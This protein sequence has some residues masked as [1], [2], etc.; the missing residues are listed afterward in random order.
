[1]A[2]ANLTKNS[3]HDLILKFTHS[4][5]RVPYTYHH[6]LV[7]SRLSHLKEMSRAEVASFSKDID[8]VTLFASALCYLLEQT[9]M[10][11]GLY[12]VTSSE[13]RKLCEMALSATNK[14]ILKLEDMIQK[15][16]GVD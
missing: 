3:I 5:S 2:K 13:D 15:E 7:R 16:K 14:H 8:E 11:D 12:I 1:M 6:D 10:V 4:P 9:N